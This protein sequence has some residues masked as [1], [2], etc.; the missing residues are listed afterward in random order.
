MTLP[1]HGSPHHEVR[2]R[3]AGCRERLRKNRSAHHRE[4]ERAGARDVETGVESS[5]VGGGD[6][7]A[8][9]DGGRTRRTARR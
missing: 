6:D 2:R 5:A 3:I 1:P 8:E 9:G 7:E 4:P